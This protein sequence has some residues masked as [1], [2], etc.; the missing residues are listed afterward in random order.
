MGKKDKRTQK[1]SPPAPAAPAPGLSPRGK[2]L[3]GAG[4]ALVVIGFVVLSRADALARNWA[5]VLAPF[6][7]LGGYACLGVGL[8]LPPAEP[9]APPAPPAP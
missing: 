4:I 3:S 9:P 1:A 8:F 5:G 2:Q 7:I 6:L